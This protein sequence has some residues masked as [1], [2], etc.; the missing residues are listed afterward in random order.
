MVPQRD[1]R[2]VGGGEPVV[3]GGGACMPC[4]FVVQPLA[5]VVCGTA[6]PTMDETIHFISE[7]GGF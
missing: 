3:S 1:P 2:R 6:M 4:G 5:S 7:R